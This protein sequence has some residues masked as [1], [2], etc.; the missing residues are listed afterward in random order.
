MSLNQLHPLVETMQNVMLFCSECKIRISNETLS[1]QLEY[2]R[3][4]N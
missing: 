1:I 3:L 4:S 2:K